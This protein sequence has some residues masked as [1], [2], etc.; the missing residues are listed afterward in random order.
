MKIEH[1]RYFVCFA[2]SVSINQAAKELYI[3]QQQLNR[4]LTSLE[5]EVHA[6]LFLRSNRGMKLTEDGKEF[7]KYASKILMEYSAMQNYFLK[8]I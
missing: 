3:S 6:Q 7:A 2:N 8:P 4:I 1:L 5:E